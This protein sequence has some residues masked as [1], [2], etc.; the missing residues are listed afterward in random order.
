[1]QGVDLDDPPGLVGGVQCIDQDQALDP[2]HPVDQRGPGAVEGEQFDAVRH[3]AL[4]QLDDMPA[5]LVVAEWGAD[6][7]DPCHERRTSR[8]RKCVA[9]EMQGS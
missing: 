8:R 6:T 3:P 5:D 9:H 4:Q 7:D 2:A 1:M